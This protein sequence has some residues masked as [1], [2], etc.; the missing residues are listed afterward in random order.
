[1]SANYMG[2]LDPPKNGPKI[3]NSGGKNIHKNSKSKK[4]SKNPNLNAKK[5]NKKKTI[6]KW[7]KN[8]KIPRLPTRCNL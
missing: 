4:H 6:K 2:F 5:Q 8:Q 7:K 3:K 1:M